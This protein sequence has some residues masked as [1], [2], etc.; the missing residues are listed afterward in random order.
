MFQTLTF[1]STTRSRSFVNLYAADRQAA[2]GLL[3]WVSAWRPQRRFNLSQL[4]DAEKPK[5]EQLVGFSGNALSGDCEV[6]VVGDY[7]ICR[8]V[9]SDLH[10]RRAPT[11]YLPKSNPNR[12]R[13]SY[14]SEPSP[15]CQLVF[16]KTG[17][18]PGSSATMK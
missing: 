3:S 9:T 17:S 2:Q 18:T 7:Q 6:I 13:A 4:S 1:S 10:A 16:S 11:V 8:H 15:S 12:P 14:T 5:G